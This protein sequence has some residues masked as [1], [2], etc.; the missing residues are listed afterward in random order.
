MHAGKNMERMELGC[1][2]PRNAKRCWE[3]SEAWEDKKKK[4][5]FFPRPFGG[6]KALLTLWFGTASLQSCERRN[7]CCFESVGL[8]Y[9][10]P[11]ECNAHSKP[12][13]LSPV[14]TG[15]THG[16]SDMGRGD[17]ERL[18]GY[19]LSSHLRE[20]LYGHC[21]CRFGGIF[22]K[23]IKIWSWLNFRLEISLSGSCH[24]VT[25]PQRYKSVRTN[26]NITWNTV[27][28]KRAKRP[29]CVNCSTSMQQNAVRPLKGLKDWDTGDGRTIFWMYKTPPN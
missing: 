19:P 3:P 18:L 10:D 28:L 20:L 11:R 22:T 16:L 17:R 14:L 6:S 9:S 24:I 7:S 27:K 8:G 12:E 21:H 2:Q 26:N 5:I 4:K 29:A 13:K 25:V 15:W 1:H 23:G